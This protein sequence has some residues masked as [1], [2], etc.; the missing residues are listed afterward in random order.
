MFGSLLGEGVGAAGT[1]V[2]GDPVGPDELGLSG[3]NVGGLDG[4][5]SAV[6]NTV[7]E[8]GFNGAAVGKLV[9]L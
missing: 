1:R 2:S 8:V 9:G 3:S 6:G 5:G 4:V 7:G